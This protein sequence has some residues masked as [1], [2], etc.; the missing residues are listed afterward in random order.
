MGQTA[1]SKDTFFIKLEWTLV[2]SNGDVIWADTI[3]SEGSSGTWNFDSPRSPENIAF[4]RVLRKS[5]YAMLSSQAIQQFVVKKYPG[6]Q[7]TIPTNRIADPVVLDLCDSLNSTNRGEL[8]DALKELREIY[9]SEAVP[10]ILPC[11]KNPD[12]GVVREAC[13]TLAVLGN[14]NT[15]PDIEPLLNNPREDIRKDA[16]QAIDK[17]NPNIMGLR[18][19]LNSTNQGELKD[20]LKKLRDMHAPEVVPN[21]VPCLKNPDPGVVREACRTLAV[22]GNKDTIPDIEPLLNNPREDIRKDAQKAIDILRSKSQ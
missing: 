1:F 10:Y 3:A 22:L 11:L 20:T 8:K 16:Q 7:R 5:Q 9:A 2:E 18:S 19:S 4:E 6:A 12:P 15:V 17:L 14:K 13:R 21:I